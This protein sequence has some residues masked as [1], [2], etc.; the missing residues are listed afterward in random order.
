MKKIAIALWATGTALTAGNP[1]IAADK[2]L[3]PVVVSGDHVRIPATTVTEDIEAAPASVTVL[4]RRDL[5]RMSVSTYGDMFRSVAGAVVNEYGQGLV[6]YEVKMRGFNSGH[7]RDMAFFLDGMPLNVTGSQHTN[8]YADL[9]QVIAET[10][11]RVEIVRGPF[12]PYAGNHAVG[13]SVQ[14]YTD[15]N[16]SSMVKFDMDSFGRIRAVPILSSDAGPGR[17]LLALDATRGDGYQNQTD[18]KRTN[19]FARYMLPVGD[20]QLAFRLQAYDAEADAPGYIDLA[21][22][23][24]GSLSP[25]AALSPGIGDRKRQNNLVFNYRSNDIEGTGGIGTGWQSVLYFI[26]DDRHRWTNY[27]LANPIG[28]PANLGAEEDKL[29]KWGFDLRKATM[30]GSAGLPA[31][32]TLGVQ[33]DNE[34]LDALHYTSDA[35]RNSLGDALVDTDRNVRTRTTAFY[36]QYQF[37]P[38]PALKIQAGLRYD[39]LAF[40]VRLNPLDNAFGPAND[41]SSTKRQWS[42]KLG[43]AYA[44]SEGARQVDLFANLARGLKSPYPFGNFNSLPD[45][46]ISPL[47][48]AEFGLRGGDAA[49][50]SWRAALW[51]TRQDKEALFNGANIFIGNQRTNR[52]GLDLEGAYPIGP[53]LRLLAN[54]SLVRARIV[55]QGPADR[56]A[57]VPDWTALL[58]IEGKTRSDAHQF[59]WS[60]INVTVGPQPLLADNSARTRSYNR[61]TGRVAYTHP[62]LKGTKLALSVTHFDRPY[63]ETVFDFGGGQYG[64]SARPK[65][66]TLLTAQ[67]PL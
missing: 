62:S 50:M 51:R 39:Q 58:G 10:V 38:L 3:A 33:F 64:L 47:T 36:G 24:N 13:G 32:L 12:S 52:D 57:N 9:A 6:A 43:L 34:N 16:A 14:F 41:F 60:L 53:D 11:S 18:L 21:S 61:T 63:E 2:T 49:G 37:N 28:T 44:L 19:M 66:K 42:P 54:Y 59:E 48:S 7:G 56:V 35:G 15:R 55:D 17:V 46:A 8:G 22:V 23:K 67:V 5:D 26:D 45:V 20:G 1:A 65:W 40:D 27:N 31:Q 4:D 25:R 30:V 29:R